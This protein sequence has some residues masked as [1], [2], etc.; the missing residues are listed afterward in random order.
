M[1]IHKAESRIHNEYQI[2][3]YHTKYTMR[4][5]TAYLDMVTETGSA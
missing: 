1:F 5:Y 4:S 3:S 2:Q